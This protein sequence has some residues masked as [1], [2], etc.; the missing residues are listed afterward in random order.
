MTCL[1]CLAVV[2]VL[3]AGHAATTPSPPVPAP[4]VAWTGS[5]VPAFNIASVLSQITVPLGTVPVID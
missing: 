2:G 3:I 1:S 5:P 4:A